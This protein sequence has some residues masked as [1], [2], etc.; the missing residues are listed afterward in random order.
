MA[1]HWAVVARRLIES[2]GFLDVQLGYVA[3][4][5]SVLRASML[6]N[7][8]TDKVSGFAVRPDSVAAADCPIDARRLRSLSEK[9]ARIRDQIMHLADG[10]EAGRVVKLDAKRRRVEIVVV[11][12]GGRT[13]RMTEREAMGFLDTLEPWMRRQRERLM[14]ARPEDGY[15]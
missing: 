11:G 15:A 2:H 10:L 14:D 6:V 9:T 7:G 4:H 8:Y 12:K 3:L 13:E 5:L 1:T